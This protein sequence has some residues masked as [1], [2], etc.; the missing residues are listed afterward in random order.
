M[1]STYLRITFHGGSAYADINDYGET[2]LYW[3][4]DGVTQ[5]NP[6]VSLDE[7]NIWPADRDLDL[8]PYYGRVGPLA[9]LIALDGQPPW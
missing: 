5:F 2:L 7:A 3:Q 6:A 4:T 9:D 1:A 8:Y